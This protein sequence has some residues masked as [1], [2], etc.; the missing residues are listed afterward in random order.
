MVALKETTLATGASVPMTNAEPVEPLE[1][2]EDWF[3]LSPQPMSRKTERSRGAALRHRVER[4]ERKEAWVDIRGKSLSAVP[5]A[6]R[7]RGADDGRSGPGRR[8]SRRVLDAK[9]R[10]SQTVI[11]GKRR[12]SAR[13]KRAREPLMVS[14]IDR[15]SSP[16]QG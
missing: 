16:S 12:R 4:R 1:L 13:S 3:M 11:L 9:A 14:N 7:E 10:C 8:G 6:D 2:L 15:R 5:E